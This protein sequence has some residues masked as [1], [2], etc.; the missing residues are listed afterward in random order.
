MCLKKAA[1]FAAFCLLLAVFAPSAGAAPGVTVLSRGVENA[2][3]ELP[4]VDG[5]SDVVMQAKINGLLGNVARDLQA[6]VQ[7]KA[8]LNYSYKVW[9]NTPEF[10]S[11]MLRVD[12]RGAWQAAQGVNIHL[13][14]GVLCSTK[15]L[16]TASDGFFAPLEGQ[17]GWRP[18]ADSPLALSG[19]GLCFIRPSDGLEQQ[20]GYEKVFPFLFVGLAG[21]YLDAYRLT[22][23]ADG[24][25]VRAA[26]GNLL[27]VLLESNRSS[28]YYWQARD[29]ARPVLQPVSSGHVL[30]GGKAIRG[31]DMLILGV[32]APG[33]AYLEI[34]YKRSGETQA[35]KTI[36]IQ[37]IG[38]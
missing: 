17:L 10:L 37:V 1:C 7:G 5:L 15:E 27:V 14:A 32:A 3:G 28:G 4:E 36:K 21:H 33:E 20:V 18:T 30:G 34:D 26:V 8:E 25:L 38:G 29:N 13:S 31:W 19:R 22:A 16:F 9:R 12:S 24:K 23:A 11:I 2:Y 35:A 6:K